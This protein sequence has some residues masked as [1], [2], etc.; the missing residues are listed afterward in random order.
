MRSPLSQK[1]DTKETVEGVLISGENVDNLTMLAVPD[2]TNV[3]KTLRTRLL[4]AKLYTKVG[5]ACLIALNPY[6]QVE[7][8]VQVNTVQQYIEEYKYPRERAKRLEPHVFQLSAD[9]YYRLRRLAEDQAIVFRYMNVIY[10]AKIWTRYLITL[11]LV[12][13]TIVASPLIR[14]YV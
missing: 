9:A 10:S 7:S 11:C 12:E 1:T 8:D 6:S 3:A 2:E 13:L 14:S 5:S 4:N